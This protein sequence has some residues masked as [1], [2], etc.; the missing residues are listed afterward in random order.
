MFASSAEKKNCY[1]VMGFTP[2]RNGCLITFK[3]CFHKTENN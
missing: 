2:L 1:D 3:K